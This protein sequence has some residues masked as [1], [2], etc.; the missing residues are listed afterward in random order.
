MEVRMLPALA[1]LPTEDVV[2]TYMVSY[3][4]WNW[5][6]NMFINFNWIELLNIFLSN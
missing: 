5:F 1:Y 2:T 6:I 3:K 4:K